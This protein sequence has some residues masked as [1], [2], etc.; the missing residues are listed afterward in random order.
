MK[1][2][3]M[4]HVSET[5][6]S[7]Q[8]EGQT[9]GTPAVF[10]RLTGCNLLCQGRGWVCDTL[11]VW[12]RGVKL[13]FKK[14]LPLDCVMHLKRGAHLVVTGGEPLLHQEALADY[15][16]WFQQNYNFLPKIEIETNGTIMPNYYLRSVVFLWNCSPKLAN[17]GE[18][19][20]KRFDS[21]VIKSLNELNS[22]FKFVVCDARDMNEIKNRWPVFIDSDKVYLMPAGASREEL[23]KTQQ[24]TADLCKKYYFKYCERI[25][26]G[27]WNKKTGV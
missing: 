11:E 2:K 19:L 23:K 16:M 15:L 3:T 27:V 7:V 8:G 26:I 4:L 12:K 1:V 25:H 18:D 24:L 5:F 13:P 20:H 21:V 22:V 6:Y 17:S 9:S 10:L 14:V